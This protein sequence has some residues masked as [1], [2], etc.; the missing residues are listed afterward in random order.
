MDMKLIAVAC[1][2]LATLCAMVAAYMAIKASKAG[3][4]FV[5][6]EPGTS[7]GSQAYLTHAILRG[8]T[9]AGRFSELAARWATGSAVFSGVA[10][11]L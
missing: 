7:Q 9:T 1:S 5:G 8:Q 10:A 4:E 11:F 2:V 6:T 3:P